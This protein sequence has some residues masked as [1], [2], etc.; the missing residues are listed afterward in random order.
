MSRFCNDLH[1][2]ER[3]VFCKTDFVYDEF[4][5]LKKFGKK[6]I[7]IIANSDITVS[8]YMVSQCPS[9]VSHIFATNTICDIEKVTPLPIG[10]EMEERANRQGHGEINHGIFEKKPFL[11]KEKNV[12][13]SGLVKDKIYS[14][15]NISTNPKVRTP[16]LEFCKNNNNFFFETGISF[17]KFVEQIKSHIATLSPRGNG[18]ECIR[19]YE[20]LYLDSIPIVFGDYHEYKAINEKIYKKLPIVFVHD[21]SQLTDFH[22]LER[23]ISEVKNNSRELLDYYYWVNL[24][25]KTASKI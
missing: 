2:G 23:K 21:Y 8:D 19:T 24:I 6:V 25:K 16:L 22:S 10:V 9:N 1:D 18:I 12:E 20:V 4:E 5:R 17:P 15:F 11:L 7:L 3:I 13:L 14:N